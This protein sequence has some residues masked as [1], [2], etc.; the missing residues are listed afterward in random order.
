[1]REWT[2]E[3]Q[4]SDPKDRDALQAYIAIASAPLLLGIWM[5]ISSVDI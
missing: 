5:S 4:G 2:P 3:A 1:M